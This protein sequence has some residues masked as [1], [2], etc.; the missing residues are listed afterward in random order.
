MIYCV[1]ILDALTKDFF[2]RKKGDDGGDEEEEEELDIDVAPKIEDYKPI[3]S[4]LKR[5]REIWCAFVIQRAFR[6]YRELRGPLGEGGGDDDDDADKESD[7]SDDDES[8]SDVRDVNNDGD[9]DDDDDNTSGDVS[10]EGVEEEEET[11][12]SERASHPAGTAPNSHQDGCGGD[13]TTGDASSP[14][15]RRSQKAPTKATRRRTS[16]SRSPSNNGRTID[17]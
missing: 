8:R 4:T 6:A 17:V 7:K 13:T 14:E 1:D 12:D 11:M 5:Q 10:K 2:A 16:V 9:D 3:S 15:G